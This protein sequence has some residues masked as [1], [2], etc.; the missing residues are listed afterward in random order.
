LE[1]EEEG[2][3]NERGVDTSR[4]RDTPIRENTTVSVTGSG[5]L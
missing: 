1:E 4:D 5:L 3:N 2:D